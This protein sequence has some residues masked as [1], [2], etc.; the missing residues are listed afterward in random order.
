MQ[1]PSTVTRGKIG[2]GKS[3]GAIDR[4]GLPVQIV[5][6]KI[7]LQHGTCEE[8]FRILPVNAERAQNKPRVPGITSGIGPG[9]FTPDAITDKP[10]IQCQTTICRLEG[11]ATAAARGGSILIEEGRQVGEV[12]KQRRCTCCQIISDRIQNGIFLTN[13]D[14]HNPELTQCHPIRIKP[15]P[16]QCGVIRIVGIG[17]GA[18]PDF[19]PCIPVIRIERLL[20]I[21]QHDI[22]IIGDCHDD[23]ILTRRLAEPDLI[24]T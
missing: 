5:I 4:P 23:F 16:D 24:G 9:Y 17:N 18:Y 7:D 2:A 8:A 10:S 22:F 19:L 11:E 6:R 21:F 1:W 13:S 12:V 14:V 20:R 15:V 3:A